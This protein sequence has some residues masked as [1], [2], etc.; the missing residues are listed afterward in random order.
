MSQIKPV[1]YHDEGRAGLSEVYPLV[2]VVLGL[3]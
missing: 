3:W 2:E 1:Y